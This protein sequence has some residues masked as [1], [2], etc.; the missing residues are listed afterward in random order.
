MELG[1]DIF[2]TTGRAPKPVHAAVVRELEGGDL[3]L[4]GEEKG[5]KA[6]AIKRLSDRHHSLARALA[7][8]M[9]PGQAGLTCGYSN[10]RV[11]I[12]IDDP[13]FKE[14][15]VFYRQDVHNEYLGLHE[16]LSG[17]AKDAAA[18]IADRLEEDPTSISIGQLLEITKMGADRTGHGPATSQTNINLNVNLADRLQRAR[19]RVAS[20]T[21]EG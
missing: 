1:L 14:L 17:L 15:L 16:Q 18:E 12:L 4:L 20:R 8:G 21:I 2:R 11:S 9:A 7:S 3:L 13:T 10:S 5:V 19:E 6:S